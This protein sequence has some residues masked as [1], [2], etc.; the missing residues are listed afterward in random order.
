MTATNKSRKCTCHPDD[1]PPVPCAHRYALSECVRLAA[2]VN[3]FLAWKLP[4]SVCSDQCANIPGYPNRSGTNLLTADE[5]RQMIEYLLA[6]TAAE[7][8]E[9]R[10]NKLEQ[11]G[12]ADA[13]AFAREPK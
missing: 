9:R 13:A 11:L 1:K 12:F 2:L 8:T 4:D 3:R 7:N 10:L 6:P 5:A